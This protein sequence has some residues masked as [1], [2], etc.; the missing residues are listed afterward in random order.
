MLGIV[1]TLF[2]PEI[3]DRGLR[4]GLDALAPRERDVFVI[5]DLQ[6]Y[7]EMEGG[8][9]DHI[10]NAPGKF[11]WLEDT[12]E[13]IGDIE[14]LRLIRQLR[15][16]GSDVGDPARQLCDKYHEA[17]EVRWACL[18][19]YLHTEGIQLRWEREDA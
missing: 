18:E 4:F 10:D 2:V 9:A 15:R 13:R 1:D 8:F 3:E 19:R 17:R 6:L 11:D 16:T 14:S 5:Y 7:H 12:L